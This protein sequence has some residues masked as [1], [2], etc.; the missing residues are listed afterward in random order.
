MLNQIKSL[1]S[2]VNGVSFAQIQY[3]TKVATAA[4]YK[5]LNITKTTKANVQIFNNIKEFT[6]VYQNAVQR[7]LN[8]QGDNTQFEVQDNYFFHTDIY[9]IVEHKTNGK[10]YLYAIFNGRSTGE[11]FIDGNSATKEDVAVYLTNSA[12]DKLLNP[13]KTT[14]NV[15]NDIDHSVVVRTIALENLDSITAM[16]QTLVF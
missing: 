9:S 15:L 5:G 4:A 2:N 13:P 11:Y 8:K 10:L 6:N 1:L 16:K 3:T 14:H 7:N 12:R